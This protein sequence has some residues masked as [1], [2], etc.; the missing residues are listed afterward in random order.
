VVT[1]R[2]LGRYRFNRYDGT[3]DRGHFELA[4]RRRADDLRDGRSA[5]MVGKGALDCSTSVLGLL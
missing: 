5:A 1:R 2:A 4:G 3:R